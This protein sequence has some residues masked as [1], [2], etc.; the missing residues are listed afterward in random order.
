MNSIGA[1]GKAPPCNLKTPEPAVIVPSFFIPILISIEVE[2]VG[3]VALNTSDL[4]ITNLTGLFVL[5]DN[6]RATGSINIAV[7]PPNPPPISDGVTR[8][9]LVSMSKSAAQ[10]FCT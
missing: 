4:L 9:A 7:L 6:A 3:P 2:E 8:N 10:V 5:R 1:P